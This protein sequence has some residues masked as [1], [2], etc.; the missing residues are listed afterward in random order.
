[1]FGV[2]A[3]MYQ[4]E[5]RSSKRYECS[6]INKNN[7]SS[8]VHSRPNLGSCVHTTLP[9]S[10]IMTLLCPISGAITM[11]TTFCCGEIQVSSTGASDC[12][13]ISCH[14]T[15]RLLV[16]SPKHEPCT[17]NDV[18]PIS[19]DRVCDSDVIFPDSL[20]QQLPGYCHM[21]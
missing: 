8:M 20:P 11:V 1:M 19:I 15:H 18:K 3:C 16:S 13:P 7:L 14:C 12:V 21:L 10:S 17:H 2:V 5:R 6:T 9:L 4:K